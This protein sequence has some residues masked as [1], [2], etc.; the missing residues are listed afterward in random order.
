[1]METKALLK[2]V[3]VEGG[4]S[5]IQL[6]ATPSGELFE[7]AKHAGEEVYVTFDP[8]QLTID[9]ETGEVYE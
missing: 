5:V 9:P 2:K 1:M 3:S 7:I 4:K 6:E 8:T